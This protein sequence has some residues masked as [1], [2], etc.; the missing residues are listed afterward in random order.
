MSIFKLI[1]A[2]APPYFKPD[3]PIAT[4]YAGLG[5]VIGKEFVQNFDI[6][7]AQFGSNGTLENWMSPQS[8]T[9]FGPTLGC[10]QKQYNGYC[11]RQPNICIN[12]SVTQVQNFADNSGVSAAYLTYKAHALLHGPEP[13]LPGELRSFSMDQVF[14]LSFAQTHCRFASAAFIKDWLLTM[15]FSTDR[16]KVIGTLRNLRAFSQA[17]QCDPGYYMSSNNSCKLW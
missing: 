15:P 7:G 5:H 11:Y 12:G 16:F 8:Q 9:S 10:L 6:V 3:W 2:M 17:F 14:F 4:N 1:L 13:R